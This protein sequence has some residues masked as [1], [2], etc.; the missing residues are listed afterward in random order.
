M[1][2]TDIFYPRNRQEWYNWLKANHRTASEI[3]LQRYVKASGKPSITYDDL[4]E[5]CLCFGWIDSV[6]KKNCSD[7]NVQRITPRR[8]K[9]T[10][11]SELNR[12]RVWKLQ[13]S[14]EMTEAGMQPIRDQIGSPDDPFDIPAWLEKRLQADQEVWQN[15]QAFPHFYKRLKVGWILEIGTAPSRQADK[16]KRIAYLIKMTKQGKMYGTQPLK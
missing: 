13:Q 15:F 11:L 1:E 5:A 2:I 7:G 6:V 16:E 3:W 14:G 10:F 9:K 4:V 12:Q 8:K